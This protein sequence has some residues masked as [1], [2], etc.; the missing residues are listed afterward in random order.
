MCTIKKTAKGNPRF[1]LG[2]WLIDAGLILTPKAD[3]RLHDAVLHLSEEFERFCIVRHEHHLSF[4]MAGVDQADCGCESR[5]EPITVSR[6]VIDMVRGMR[7][8]ALGC[9]LTEKGIMRRSTRV[10]AAIRTQPSPG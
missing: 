9:R 7:T 2:K 4:V 5:L 10:H 1:E 6:G 3:A 8:K